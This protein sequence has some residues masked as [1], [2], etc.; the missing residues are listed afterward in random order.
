MLVQAQATPQESGLRDEKWYLPLGLLSIATYLKHNGFPEISVLDADHDSL[1]LIITRLQTERPSLVGINFNVFNTQL[2]DDVVYAAKS[3]DA[4]VVVGGQAA[5]PIP[6]RILLSNPNID[7]VVLNDGE[8]PMLDIARRLQ[9]GSRDVAGIPNV[10][11]R[12]PNSEVFVPNPSQIQLANLADIPSLDRRING[13]DFDRYLRAWNRPDIDPNRVATSMYMQKGCAQHCT[14][15]ARIDKSL[16]QRPISQ[17]YGELR[18]LS[19]EGVNYVYIV[20]DTIAADK[21]FLRGLAEILEKNPLPMRFWAFLDARNIDE[22]SVGYMKTVG[23]EKVLVGIETGNEYLRKKNGKAYSNDFL[24]ERVALLGKAGIKLED[25]YVLGLAGETPKTIYDTL[26]LSQQVAKLCQ[27]EG[28]AFNKMTPLMGS[29]DWNRLMNAIKREGNLTLL[30][31]Y[32][33]G[34]HFS[35]PEVRQHYFERFC[36]FKPDEIKKVA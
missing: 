18:T 13:F 1:D 34:Y 26:L 23:M 3:I 29:P 7:A 32:S 8:A 17:I 14:F 11:Y 5:T 9:S 15:C 12:L 31:H 35:I 24:L 33:Q 10:S 21:R 27:T 19:K 30:Q 6:K 25:S 16:R 22:E 36:H 4:Y 20:D 28:T 2:L